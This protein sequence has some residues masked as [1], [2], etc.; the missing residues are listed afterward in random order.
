MAKNSFLA[1]VTC[2]VSAA[3][4]I[5]AQIQ[6]LLQILSTNKIILELM[7]KITLK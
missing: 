6:S 7:E 4:L 2:G 5:S 1:E 3:L